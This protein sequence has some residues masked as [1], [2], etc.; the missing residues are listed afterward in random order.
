MSTQLV[1][2]GG[3]YLSKVLQLEHFIY[4]RLFLRLLC[5]LPCKLQCEQS[6][7]IYQEKKSQHFCTY[8]LAQNVLLSCLIVCDSEHA[9][10]NLYYKIEKVI[11]TL[12]V[13]LFWRHSERRNGNKK[14]TRKRKHTFLRWIYQY[15]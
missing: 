4:H 14:S 12:Q 8:L 7:D 15:A 9:K 11:Q 3:N 6:S 10:S 2:W 1:G 5:V 13:T